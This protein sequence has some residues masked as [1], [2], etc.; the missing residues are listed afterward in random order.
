MVTKIKYRSLERWF[1]SEIKFPSSAAMLRCKFALQELCGCEVIATPSDE[2]V[3]FEGKFTFGL[4]DG[5]FHGI[6]AKHASK[7][8]FYRVKS[9]FHDPD[10][11]F[12]GWVCDYNTDGFEFD[13]ISLNEHFE[14]PTLTYEDVDIDVYQVIASIYHPRFE[15][16][17][18]DN[19]QKTYQEALD[20]KE[21]DIDGV[22][23]SFLSEDIAGNHLISILPLAE[24]NDW[25]S[26]T[27][28]QP[29]TH[30]FLL[31]IQK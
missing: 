29:T 26:T 31:L 20:N 13:T 8:H 6:I 4:F 21:L 5:N 28:I 17:N 23:D 24:S 18:I 25:L 2:G 1:A 11:Y 22:R 16:D 10:G 27:M 19:V 3:C 15:Q 9:I 7:H 14:R 30:K 12:G